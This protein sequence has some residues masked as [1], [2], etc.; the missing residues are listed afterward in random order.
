MNKRLDPFN[1]ETWSRDERRYFERIDEALEARENKIISNG[2]AEHAAYIIHKFLTHAEHKVRIFSGT[3]SRSYKGA[4]VYANSHITKA[5]A[6]FVSGEERELIVIVQDGL[7]LKPGEQDADHPLARAVRELKEEG[8]M[9]GEL[10]IRQL[11]DDA[12]E[13]L[14][15]H[16]Y[17]NH[18]M[19]MD[20]HAYRLETNTEEAGAHVNFSDAETAGALAAIFDRVLY[21]GSTELVG[22]TA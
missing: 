19:V 20:D 1:K 17:C 3:L 18:W 16:D 22:I 4:S 8:R 6:A 21:P 10:R 12:M 13:F 9:Q 7:D 11:G 5:A 14:R 15:E 2:K